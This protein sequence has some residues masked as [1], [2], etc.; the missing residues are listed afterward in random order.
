MVRV[1]IAYAVALLAV[2]QAADVL[3]PALRLPSWSVSLVAYLG[4]LGL[5]VVIALAWLNEPDFDSI[6]DDPG[7]IAI[8]KP[9][10]LPI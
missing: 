3:A 6:R 7:F 8:R 10:V 4:L 5:P 9:V 2:L 1:V